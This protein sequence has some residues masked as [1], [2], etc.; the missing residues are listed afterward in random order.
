MKC[1]INESESR[2]ARTPHN[3]FVI[4]ILLFHLMLAPAAIVIDIGMYGLL[5]PLVVSLSVI[6]FIYLQSRKA[7]PWFV[8]AHWRLT[9][10]RCRLLMFGYAVTAL[11]ML[12]AWLV[13]MGIADTTM[14]DILYTA[15]TRIGIMP[16][17]VMVMVTVVLEAGGLN[18][19]SR[20][21]VPE[22]IVRLFPPPDG[23]KTPDDN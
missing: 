6:A 18:Q 14:K 5:L 2:R 20:G 4:N 19:V 10:R 8:A 11:F 7:V 3:L 13:T 21:E 16:T 17:L 22:S 15:I 23:M 1:L 9:F 12:V